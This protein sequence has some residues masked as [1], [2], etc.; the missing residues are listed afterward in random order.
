VTL[1]LEG[2]ELSQDL[3]FATRLNPLTGLRHD[4]RFFFR[5]SVWFFEGGAPAVADRGR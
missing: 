1:S 3:K 4:I 2:Q 5:A